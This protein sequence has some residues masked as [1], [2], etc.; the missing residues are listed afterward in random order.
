MARDAAPAPQ[1]L[2]EPLELGCSLRLFGALLAKVF[3]SFWLG[4][5]TPS[6]R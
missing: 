3:S 2:G 5:D 1:V 6:L 4:E